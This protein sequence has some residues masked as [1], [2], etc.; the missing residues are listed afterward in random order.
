M[1][2]VRASQTA[3]TSAAP[4]TAPHWRTVRPCSCSVVAHIAVG[5]R[6]RGGWWSPPRLHATSGAEV[7]LQG[8]ELALDPGADRDDHSNEA[9]HDHASD[10]GVLDRLKAAVVGE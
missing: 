3:A 2:R 9:G 7:R 5:R 1:R 8:T 6:R 10:N 4:R